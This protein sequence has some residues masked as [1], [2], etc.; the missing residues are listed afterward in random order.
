MPACARGI[1][2]PPKT[3]MSELYNDSPVNTTTILAGST[4]WA[5]GRKNAD[6]FG[7]RQAL[8][9]YTQNEVQFAQDRRD[10]SLLDDK[11]QQLVEAKNN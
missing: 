9:T 11:V 7:N 6:F 4:F 10:L 5:G 1:R 3:S 8:K 2:Q